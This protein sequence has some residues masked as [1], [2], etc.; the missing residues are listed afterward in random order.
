[1]RRFQKSNSPTAKAFEA[2]S[3]QL[4]VPARGGAPGIHAGV[5]CRGAVTFSLQ[6]FKEK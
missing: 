1:V 5:F 6:P 4:T 3:S 2:K